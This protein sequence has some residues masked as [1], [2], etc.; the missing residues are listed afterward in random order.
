[1]CVE[2]LR[3]EICR[4]VS[5][6]LWKKIVGNLRFVRL[7]VVGV[8]MV[9]QIPS[10]MI[11]GGRICHPHSMSSGR[12]MAC[13]SSFLVLAFKGNL[14]LMY[15]NSES[16]TIRLG[17]G[18]NGGLIVGVAPRMH[19]IS[20]HSRARHSQREGGGSKTKGGTIIVWCF[21]M[22]FHWIVLRLWVC[23]S[24]LW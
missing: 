23:I 8:W 12:S 20:G 18:E 17:F 13:L 16:W 24:I 10:V 14:S 1:M 4:R 21:T 7:L 9:P 15:V 2:Y 3:M 19:I 22:F 5:M 11:T 6:S